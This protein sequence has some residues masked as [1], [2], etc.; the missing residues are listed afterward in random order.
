MA[1]GKLATG[2]RYDRK[3]LTV[4]AASALLAVGVGYGAYR[5]SDS[6]GPLVD[7][8]GNEVGGAF[9]L[10]DSS[11]GT[12]TANDF[13]GRWMLMMFGAIHCAENACTKTLTNL[14]GALKQV[15]PD[16]K[17]VAALFISLDPQRDLSEQLRRYA[18]QFG[19]RIVAGTG[20][21]AT[22]AAVTKEYHAPIE[23]QPDPEW[24]Y[25]Y[26]MSPRIVVMDPNGRYAGTIESSA[27]EG[28]M[29]QRLGALLEKH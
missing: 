6:M 11:D 10:M 1:G 20:S 4:L 19:S 12:M 27:N 21:P 16:G 2:R 28:E 26:V 15:D 7:S 5:L 22:L 3:M 17:Y 14:T 8:Q 29:K 18:T 24:G 13:H 23:K 25:A 9:R